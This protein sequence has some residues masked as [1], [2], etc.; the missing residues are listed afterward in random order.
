[1]M[2]H[3][4]SGGTGRHRLLIV[5]DEEA[6]LFAHAR[7]LTTTGTSVDTADN[8]DSALQLLDE[9]T[10]DAVIVDLRLSGAERME[11]FD[12]IKAAKA[13]RPDTRVVVTTAYAN[14]SVRERIFAEHAD[15]CMEKPVSPRDVRGILHSLGVL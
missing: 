15:Y 6:I 9:N 3:H 8:L 7:M 13:R 2:A 10:Y 4:E 12:V 14:D 11:G 5:D 1:M